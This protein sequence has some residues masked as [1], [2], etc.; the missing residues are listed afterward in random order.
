MILLLLF[1]GGISLNYW[2]NSFIEKCNEQVRNYVQ[3]SKYRNSIEEQL[4][5][6]KI[7]D[8]FEAKREY[9]EPYCDK[10]SEFPIAKKLQVQVWYGTN[11]ASKDLIQNELEKKLAQTN[12]SNSLRLGYTF[13][14]MVDGAPSNFGVQ[15]FPKLKMTD[16]E[17]LITKINPK[18][19]NYD[20]LY[21]FWITSGNGG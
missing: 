13:W 3:D 5:N 11:L 1:V 2:F 6:L 4:N 7:K 21:R 17:N 9:I 14:D 18:L 15:N 20:H 19:L 10:S 16:Y 12:N 8:S